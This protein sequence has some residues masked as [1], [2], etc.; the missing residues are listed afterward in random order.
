MYAGIQQNMIN[1][2][3]GF[4]VRVPNRYFKTKVPKSTIVIIATR[5][6]TLIAEKGCFMG[7]NIL[8]QANTLKSL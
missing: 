4:I 5:R 6:I 7:Q 2:L 8:I 3:L 1:I